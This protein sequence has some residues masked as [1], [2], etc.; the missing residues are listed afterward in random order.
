MTFSSFDAY[1]GLVVWHSR[2]L[3][4]WTPI[5]PAL[6]K[7]VGAVWAP[8][9]VKHQ[10]RYYIYFPGVGPY[11]SNYVVWAD[12]IRGPWSDPIDLKIGRIDPGHAVG[13]DGRRY[14]FLSAGYRVALADDGL[15]VIGEPVK[16]Y[17]GWPIPESYVIEGFAQEGPKI[18]RRGDYY[19]MVL[20][21]GGTAGPPTGHMIVA[22]RSRSIDG[23]WENSPYNPIV[24]TRSGAEPWW[25]RGHGT[26]VEDAA[27]QW[28]MVYHAYEKDYLTLGRQT[29]LE[30]VEWTSDGWFRI[31]AGDPA[32]PIVKPSAAAGGAAARGDARL[33][34]LGRLHP[35]PHGR[36]VELLR[37]RRGRHVAG[38]LRRRRAGAAGQG[39]RPG[40]ELAVVVRRRRSRLRDRGRHRGR[41]R[42]VGGAAAVLQPAAVRR[43]RLLGHEL[44]HAQLR[45]G[46][47]AGQA[48]RRRP[49]APHPPAQRSPHRHDALQ[50][51]RRAVGALRPRHGAVGLPPQRRLRVLEPPPGAL[52]RRHRRG[53]LPPVHVSRAACGWNLRHGCATAAA[54]PSAYADPSSPAG[55]RAW[56]RLAMVPGT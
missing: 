54:A 29:L 21:E 51:G 25:S 33:R 37:R 30:P 17:D 43:P 2:D 16:V 47:S 13:P 56:H 53:P 24:R 31:R 41:S 7:N 55:C 32:R 1:P 5:G 44:L 3:V 20:A 6:R 12:D 46:P 36:A 26:L 11:R 52:R 39:R 23:P 42:R 34:V 40:D 15:S 38:A 27:G 8:D 4:N 18:L 9:L 35:Q 14:L 48:G 10:G 49:A 50:R 19:Y 22:A 28:W 45:A